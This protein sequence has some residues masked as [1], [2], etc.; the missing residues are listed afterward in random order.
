MVKVKPTILFSTYGGHKLGTGH[1]FRDLELVE[2]LKPHTKAVFHI[3]SSDRAFNIFHK[4]GVNQVLR[5]SLRK[6]VQQSNPDLII[7]DRPYALGRMAETG[8]SKGI[9]VIALDYFYYDDGRVN[10]NISIKNH[11]IEKCEKVRIEN[12]Y[13]GTKYA[14]IREEI[15]KQ[16][17]KKSKP[18]KEVKNILITFG[19]ADPRNNTQK[20]IQLL[21]SISSKRFNVIILIGDIFRKGLGYCLKERIHNYTI[22]NR[23][24]EIG[25]LMSWADLAF[26]GGGTTMM[27]LLC[28]GCPLVVIPQTK[29]ELELAR[30]VAEK[31]AILLLEC[32]SFSNSDRN[33]VEELI[34]NP[35]LRGEMC[36]K[37]ME[38]F[39]GTG[40]SRIKKII[41]NELKKGMLD[42]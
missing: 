22:K 21:N 25:P 1:I 19:G 28:I 27:E 29:G 3:N 33:K 38:L 35:S 32:R 16:R 41:L 24:L 11:H 26:C 31:E 34:Q 40:K 36:T 14:I 6:A 9:K 7:Y 30:S 42:A 20:A 5:G 4:R 12:I 13:E 10:A 15:L 18:N 8:K 2:S 37:G 17:N 39:D 23:V